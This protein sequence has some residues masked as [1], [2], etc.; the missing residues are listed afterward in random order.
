MS[1]NDKFLD[2]FRQWSDQDF[3]LLLS[4]PDLV[5]LDQNSILRKRALAQTLKFYVTEVQPGILIGTSPANLLISLRE[6]LG[7]EQIP[8]RRS[9][10]SNDYIREFFQKRTASKVDLSEKNRM[11]SECPECCGLVVNGVCKYP[12]CGANTCNKSCERIEASRLAARIQNKKGYLKP[13]DLATLEISLNTK[14]NASP[15][16]KRCPKIIA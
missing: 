1:F 8:K 10:T 2:G 15:V 5:K 6:R 4:R 11:A 3:D 13:K 14:C 12:L 9:S 7:Q 16:C